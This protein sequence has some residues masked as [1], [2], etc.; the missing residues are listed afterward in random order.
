MI[1]FNLYMDRRL[2][3]NGMRGVTLLELLV[4]M[5]IIGI[6]AAI[7]VPSYRR[8]LIRSQR[9]EAKIALLQL[10]TAQEKRYLQSNAYTTDITGLPTAAIPGLGLPDRTET[11][12][13]DI[14]V[15]LND[16]NAQSYTASATPHTGGGQTDDAECYTFTINERGT[17]GISGTSTTQAC[18]K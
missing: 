2:T 16:G 14:T 5:V 4:V 13:Y 17:R 8:Y 7:G 11:S 18:W 9:S 10:Q 15:V 1:A 12:K 3:R 6:L